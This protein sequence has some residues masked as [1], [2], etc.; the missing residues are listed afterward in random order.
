MTCEYL[1]FED[2]NNEI[3]GYLPFEDDNNEILFKKNYEM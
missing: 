3:F 2:V 1:P